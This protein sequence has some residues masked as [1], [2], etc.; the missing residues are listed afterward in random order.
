MPHVQDLFFEN[1]VVY[2]CEHNADGA[3]GLIINKPSPLVMDQL[4]DAA[5]KPTP[6]RFISSA[7]HMGGPIQIDRGFLIHTPIGNWQSSLSVT[8]SIA[9]T[10][11]KDIIVG[12]QNSDEVNKIFATI[13]YTSWSEGQLEDEISNNDWLVVEANEDILFDCPIAERY[14][15]ALN[16]LGIQSAALMGSAGHA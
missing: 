12:M 2:V 11:S 16:L 4:F 1:S 13:G 3:M 5:K 8:D 14:E 15:Q 7:V 9:L 6:E 10:T